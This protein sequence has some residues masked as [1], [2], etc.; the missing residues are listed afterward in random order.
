MIPLSAAGMGAIGALPGH[1]GSV[2]IPRYSR[3]LSRRICHIGVGAFHRAHQADYL[4]RLLQQGAGEGWGIC[5]IGLRPEDQPL[6]QALLRQDLLYSLWEVDGDLRRAK[7]IGS[8]MEYI[9]ASVDSAIAVERLCEE[10]TR[11]VSMTVTESGY[12]LEADGALNLSHPDIAA[13]LRR[14]DAP[15]TMQGVVV[16]A[17][18][19]RRKRGLGGF[20]LMSCD[21]LL[22]NGHRLRSAIV[23]FAEAIDPTLARWI[24][25]EASFPSSMVDRITPAANKAL[26]ARFSTEGGFTDQAL[27]VCEG[28]QQWILEDQFVNGRPDLERV[29]VV[30][31]DQVEVFEDMKVGLLNGSHSALSHISILSGFTR[32]HEAVADAGIGRWASAYMKEV[33]ETLRPVPGIDLDDYQASLI[34]RY[35]NPVIDDRLLRLAQ[36]SSAKFRQVLRAPLLRRL[37]R[38]LTVERLAATVAF[39]ITYL[40]SLEAGRE[41][42]DAYL[43]PMKDDLIRWAVPALAR[44]RCEAFLTAT[45]SLPA[46][47]RETFALVVDRHLSGIS[48][49]GA[50]SHL[51]YITEVMPSRL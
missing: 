26:Q 37:G 28:W 6:G 24:D 41:S 33:A 8:I 27:V 10:A 7:V 4:H 23:G 38:G 25:S 17:L 19:I 32:V 31:S 44:Q 50:T 22:Q 9:D 39:W 2:D 34:Q 18:S 21:N 5:G 13:D 30:F 20:T 16:A 11:I 47:E 3:N 48:A 14:S 51:A 12:C 45:L 29:G 49:H 42:R 40:A 36:D 1:P 35:R 15:R 46:P 43:D